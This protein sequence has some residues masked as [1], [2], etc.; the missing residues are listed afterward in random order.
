MDKKKHFPEDTVVEA[1]FTGSKEI[2]GYIP[3]VTYTMKVFPTKNFPINAK[4]A[5]KEKSKILSYRSIKHFLSD[6]SS[7]VVVK[8]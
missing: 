5:E 3:H 7:I 8:K 2:M 6:W 1:V 4:D